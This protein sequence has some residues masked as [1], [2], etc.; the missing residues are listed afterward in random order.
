MV[1]NFLVPGA[2]LEPAQRRQRSGNRELSLDSGLIP[3]FGAYPLM[4]A[5][6][7]DLIQRYT[8]FF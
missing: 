3:R 2:G 7:L 8:L 4:W 5:C 1:Y 6:P